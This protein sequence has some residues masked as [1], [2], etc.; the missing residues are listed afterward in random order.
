[1]QCCV[2]VLALRELVAWEFSVRRPPSLIPPSLITQS[3]GLGFRT[4]VTG[5]GGRKWLGRFWHLG[6]RLGLPTPEPLRRFYLTNLMDSDTVLTIGNTD[7]AIN[8]WQNYMQ[9]Q[10]DDGEN[11]VSF[12]N[13][14]DESNDDHEEVK[15]LRAG[16]KEKDQSLSALQSKFDSF[17]NE[18]KDGCNTHKKPARKNEK[19]YNYCKKDGKWF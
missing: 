3:L 16:L 19:E 17:S 2:V 15:A 14:S 7:E 9:C 11:R 8:R 4:R 13:A 5:G 6:A 18:Q 1:M 12:S 10:D